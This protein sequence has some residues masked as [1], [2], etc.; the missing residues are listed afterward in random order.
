[1]LAVALGTGGLAIAGLQL[2]MLFPD[3]VSTT[4]EECRVTADI[5]QQLYA[6]FPAGAEE[7][8]RILL[9]S[10]T[11]LEPLPSAPLFSCT[12]HIRGDAP[13]GRYPIA[14]ERP[15]A[16]TPEG[17]PL[18]DAFRCLAG[19]VVVAGPPPAPTPS[20]TPDSGDRGTTGGSASGNGCQVDPR[21]PTQ[22]L[23]PLLPLALLLIGRRLWAARLR[24]RVRRPV[25]RIN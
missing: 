12:F 11:S 13:A 23:L 3:V 19:A 21:P 7:V 14:C 10:L 8:L 22:S 1:M 4:P 24:R 2:D 15:G 9:L 16:S 18:D 5:A 17:S 25:A 6:A 20:A